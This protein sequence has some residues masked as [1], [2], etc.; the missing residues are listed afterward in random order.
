[1]APTERFTAIPPSI[2]ALDSPFVKLSPAVKLLYIAL[3]TSEDRDAA[4]VVPLQWG[5]LSKVTGIRDDKLK[6]AAAELVDQT[7]GGYRL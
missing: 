1:M 6:E 4:D 7:L 3:W 2:W 5:V